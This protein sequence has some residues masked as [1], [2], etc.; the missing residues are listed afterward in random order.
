MDIHQRLQ[1]VFR[2]VF[3]NDSLVLRDEMTSRD[4]AGWDSLAHI[5]LMFS[6]ESAFGMQFIGNELADLRD[7]GEL[8]AALEKRKI[9]QSL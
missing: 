8:K 9:Q 5:N 3:N 1:Q 4:I 2:D 6:I 7:I